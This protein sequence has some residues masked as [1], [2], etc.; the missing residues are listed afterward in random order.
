[1]N[2]SVNKLLLVASLFTSTT[3]FG[4][5]SYAESCESLTAL[6]RNL[7][8]TTAV[9]K[10]KLHA[11]LKHEK[12]F[13]IRDSRHQTLYAQMIAD[14]Y[15]KLSSHEAS[16]A[17]LLKMQAPAGVVIDIVP[18]FLSSPSVPSFEESHLALKSIDGY[19]ATEVFREEGSKKAGA[20]EV[21]ALGITLVGVDQAV[22]AMNQALDA[23][24][25][26]PAESETNSKDRE[27][28]IRKRKALV[29]KVQGIARR[30]TSERWHLLEQ[31]PKTARKEAKDA[32]TIK[33]LRQT[34]NFNLELLYG[35][36]FGGFL[37]YAEKDQLP[38]KASVPDSAGAYGRINKIKRDLKAC[39]P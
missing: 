26:V 11:A 17:T 15:A 25:P 30:F 33:K 20:F 38:D 21:D 37:T 14:K 35:D 36:T 12:S 4:G 19:F 5:Q 32:S 2:K 13:A 9:A 6:R 10:G 23:I 31:M 24:A 28:A 29:K 7:M 22:A 3:L 27:Q 18:D 1:M 34:I 8:N 39:R 16:I